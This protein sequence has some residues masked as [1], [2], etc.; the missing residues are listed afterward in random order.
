MKRNR[1]AARGR[2][3]AVLLITLV[4]AALPLAAADSP[5]LNAHQTIEP[6]MVYV[7]GMEGEP[8]VA[9]LTL[10]L[11]GTGSGGRL[12][13]DCLLVI[14][15]S[16]TAAIA[17][18]K[19]F[20]FELLD[21][22]SPQDR[23]GLVTFSTAAKL[24]IPLAGDRSTLKPAIADL[25]TGG[26][27]A[28]GEA[29]QVARK[30]LTKNGRE[31]SVLAEIL[32]TDGQSNSGRDPE[33]EGSVAHDAGIRI[34]S[35][36]IGALINRDLLQGLAAQTGGA[37]SER[38]SDSA[39][40]R[41]QTTLVVNVAA[42]DAHVEK[43]L[44][45]ELTYVRATP[46]PTRVKENPDGTTSL[47]FSAGS[48]GLGGQWSVKIDLTAKAKGTWPTDQGSLVVFTDFR[49]IERQVMV[50]ECMLAAVEPNRAPQALFA[51]EPSRPTTAD[52]VTFT[53]RSSDADGRVVAWRWDFG[54][55]ATSDLPNPEHRF[56]R[57]GIY[58]VRLTVV[59]D[60]ERWSEAFHA[61]IAVENSAPVGFFTSDPKE[62]RLGVEAF[63]DAGGSVNLD[64]RIVS[65][66]WDFD[67]D[68]AF[69]LETASPQIGHAFLEVGDETVI[70][71]VTDD[72]GKSGQYEKMLTV[73]PNVLAT[74]AIETCFPG[75]VTI[76]GG[77]VTV[78]VTLQANTE[79]QG[80]TLHETIPAGWTV[81]P[82]DHGRA[83]FRPE[84]A[85]WIF[86]EP[87]KDDDIRVIRY[88]LTAPTTGAVKAG[89]ERGELAINGL[90]GS[91]SPRVSRAVVGEDKITC[92]AILPIPVVIARW[93]SDANRINLC[94]PD[95]ISFD[96]IQYAVSLWLA[97]T[98][99]PQTGNQ[100]IDIR[101][102][103]DLIAY[104]LTKRSVFEPLP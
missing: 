52:L 54:D 79:L 89:E 24:A 66:S 47:S 82:V 77:T 50:P 11:E 102:M 46:A 1:L 83:T 62:P 98:P 78:T 48:I 9:A 8:K 40:E 91:S 15:T 42:R 12:P 10:V 55:Q 80:L 56:A 5:Y 58:T 70:L 59:D 28:L 74:R 95:E 7:I 97:G 100:R 37:F 92:A 18:A 64:G 53:D 85:D 81:S 41:I 43:T 84:T 99:V 39:R 17:E 45:P 26:K 30:E 51:Y 29:L 63:F 16:A 68:G 38:P 93:D 71:K 75:D 94:L 67:G 49:G 44:P 19:R 103:Q 73:L 104:W 57:G 76:P 88:T 101:M 2:P 32:L 20:A 21:L 3:L 22:F 31:G 69:D 86:L 36:G 27:S 60:R 23:V 4:V 96:Q 61:S 25:V 13:I 33:G 90:V 72:E 6:T 34:V 14:D 87:L 65:Y 35:V